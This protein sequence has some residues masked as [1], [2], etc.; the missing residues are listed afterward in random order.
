MD[1]NGEPVW[2]SGK[3]LGWYMVSRRTSVRFV[4]ILKQKT[5][6]VVATV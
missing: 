5:V 4:P 2:L 1:F 6:T 3:A